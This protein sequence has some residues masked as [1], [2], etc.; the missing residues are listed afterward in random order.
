MADRHNALGWWLDEAGPVEPHATLSGD[1]RADVVVVGGGY[2][3]MW[4]AWHLKRLE[5]GAEVALLEA[6]LCGN[7]PSGR[8]GG[9]VNELWFSLPTL[10]RGFGDEAARAVARAA[11]ESVAD[12]GRWCSEQEVDAWWR[13]GGYLQVSTTPLHDGVPAANAAACHDLG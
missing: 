5:P 1:V 9:F 3:G 7:G 6:D 11:T 4:A 13:A 12:I 2:T 10:R 8:N